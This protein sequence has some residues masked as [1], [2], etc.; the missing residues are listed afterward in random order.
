MNI[1]GYFKVITSLGT[2]SLILTQVKIGFWK[3]SKGISNTPLDI[4]LRY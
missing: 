1:D 4:L 2:Y 3:T